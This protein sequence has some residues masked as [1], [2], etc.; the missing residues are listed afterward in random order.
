MTKSKAILCLFVV[1]FGA[2]FMLSPI[3]MAPIFLFRPVVVS[4]YTK[5]P[6]T[7]FGI[8]PERIVYNAQSGG[9]IHGI[10]LKKPGAK[11]TVLINHGQ[12]GNLELHLGLAKTMLLAG[13]SAFIY[14]YEGFGMSSGTPSAEHMLEDGDAA[15][16]FLT[17][18]K[19]L[20]PTEIVDCG[21]SLGSGVAC[22]IAENHPCAYVV[23]IS[24]YTSIDELAAERFPY[25]NLYPNFAFPQPD[26]SCAHF[27]S[28]NKTI[29]V[30]LIHG[31]RDPVIPLHHAQD[32]DQMCKSPHLLIIDA[33]A[34]HGDFPTTFLAQQIKNFMSSSRYNVDAR[35]AQPHRTP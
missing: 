30:L 15:Y 33:N 14:D 28:T 8:V 32:L 17:E 16:T 31:A 9:K 12:G 24:P 19:H 5:I 26:M 18:N 10:C 13:M 27:V 34:H 25:M 2:Y 20:S 4:A 11:F 3:V 35:T 22:H 29:P 1:C 23:L 6:D 21:V 7:V